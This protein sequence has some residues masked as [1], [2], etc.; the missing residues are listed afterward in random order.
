MERG[1]WYGRKMSEGDGVIRRVTKFN[2]SALLAAL[3]VTN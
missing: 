1:K 3:I 2:V